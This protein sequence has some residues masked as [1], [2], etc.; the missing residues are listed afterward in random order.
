MGNHGVNVQ[1]VT[2]GTRPIGLASSSAI[3]LVGTAPDATGLDALDTVLV[4]G[5]AGAA[6]LG[7]GE[8]GTIKP[9]LDA[10]FAQSSSALVAVHCVAPGEVEG[11]PDEAATA[12]A[13]AGSAVDGTGIYA[14]LAAK[15][16]TGTKPKILIAPGY[17]SV[18]AVSS[19]LIAVGNRLLAGVILDGPDTDNAAAIAA[20]GT[21]S[22]EDGRALLVDPYVTSGG[23]SVPGSSFVAGLVAQSDAR[24]GVWRSPSNQ[25]LLG[26]EGTSRPVTFE[27]GDAS[28]DASLLNAA[29]VS[30]IIREQG[31]RFWG[32]RG[33][34]SDPM[35]AFW[36]V[37]RTDDLIAESVKD[38]HL[39]AVDQNITRGF[40]EEV[41]EGLRE[42]L[43]QLRT[44][45]AIVGFDAWVDPEVNTATSLGNG[46]LYLDYDFTPAPPAESITFRSRLTTKYLADIIG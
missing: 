15:H 39:W 22:D 36:N 34:S 25:T 14:L 38:S 11:V 4:Q 7:L 8:E 13:I 41:L 42:F 2:T 31:W 1:R 46:E 44:D 45:G 37:V 40:V 20:A 43:R 35:R 29:N 21:I 12:T 30:T 5:S 26:V 9:A 18:A 6:A 28:C 32:N 19:S 16:L 27:L 33:L 3:G 17:S 10:I 23:A 24:F